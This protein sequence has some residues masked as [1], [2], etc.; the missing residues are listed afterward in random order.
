MASLL[1]PDEAGLSCFYCCAVCSR[2]SCPTEFS[3]DSPVVATISLQHH[4]CIPRYVAFCVGSELR[5]GCA[6]S[7]SSSEPSPQV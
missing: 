7:D 3:S 4:K 2:L 6:A 5:P 1:S